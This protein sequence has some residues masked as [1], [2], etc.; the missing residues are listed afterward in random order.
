M[1]AEFSTADRPRFV[2]GSMGPGTRLPSLGA[3]NF[4]ELRDDYQV[5]AAGLLDGGADVLLVETVYDLLQAKS[6][7]VACRRAMIDAGRTAPADGAGHGRD[8]R[9]HAG[10]FGDRRHGHRARGDAAGRPRARLRDR[11]GG[12]DRAP[13]LSRAAHAYLAVVPAQPRYRRSSTATRTTTSRPTVSP[14][15]TSGSSLSSG[16]ISSAAAAAR[17]PTISRRSSRGSAP[18]RARL[19]AL[20]FEPGCSSIYSHVPYHQELTYLTVGERTTANGSRKFHDAML[21]ADWDTCVQMARDQVKEGA[22]VLDVCVDYVGHD[23]TVDMEG[24]RPGSPRRPRC[25]SSSTPPSRRSSR[26]ACSTAAGR[27]CSTP[28]TSRT[29]NPTAPASTA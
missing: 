6:A 10:G 26:P 7:I 8:H 2:V 13:P 3:I 23:S 11:T 12:D 17:R 15:R 25:H 24:T 20:D 18:T 9:A 4:A 14:T 16:S 1:A 29:A 27:P 19:R 28:R 21:A 22:H 5:Q